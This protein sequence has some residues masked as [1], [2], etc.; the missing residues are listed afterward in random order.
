MDGAAKTCPEAPAADAPVDSRVPYMSLLA[1]CA[2]P[3]RGIH[4]LC[5][6][7]ALPYEGCCSYGFWVQ[8]SA[9]AQQ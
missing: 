5:I 6:A 7:V 2:Q 8:H 1:V 4:L 3:W 9:S